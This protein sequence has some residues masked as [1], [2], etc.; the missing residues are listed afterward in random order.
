VQYVLRRIGVLIVTAW[1]ALTVNFALPKLMP[2]DPVS[3]LLARS[4]GTINPRARAAIEMQFGLNSHQSLI[5]QYFSY[6]GRILTG[7]LGRSY[8]SYPVTVTSIIRQSLPWTLGMV[9]FATILAFLL[10]SGLGMV[11]AWRRGSA[12]WHRNSRL[13]TALVPTGVMLSAMPTFW[14][15]MMFVYFIAFKTGWFPIN[16]APDPTLSRTSIAGMIDIVHHAALPAFTLTL[17]SLGGWVMLMRNS[18][19][20]VLNDDFVKFARAKGLANRTIAYRYAARN[21][22]LP[23]FT[24][25]AMALGVVVGGQVFIEIVFSYQG[26]GF[27]LLNAVNNQDYPLMQG[28]F[29][30]ITLTILLANFVVEMLYVFID[31]R[32]RVETGK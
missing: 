7:D 17:V 8:Q 25:L 32:V 28:I 31:P 16:G 24:Q 3:N 12:G 27:T 1:A 5:G 20:T 2:G 10:G 22:I 14:I 6:L 9:G 23:V 18:M 30:I 4:Q 13:D 15:S 11:A 29:L 26:I 19:L 21:A